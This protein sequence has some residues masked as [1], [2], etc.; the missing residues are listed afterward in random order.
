MRSLLGILIVLP[1]LGVGAESLRV[2]P[3]Q[4]VSLEAAAQ[5]WRSRARNAGEKRDWDTAEENL[6]QLMLAGSLDDELDQLHAYVLYHREKYKEA[7]IAL[8]RILK[9][10][11]R[12]FATCYYLGMSL[13]QLRHHAA[14][15]EIFWLAAAS[16]EHESER[17]W[18][19]RDELRE[20]HPAGPQLLARLKAAESLLEWGILLWE[21]REKDIARPKLGQAIRVCSQLEAQVKTGDLIPRCILVRGRAHQ[22]QQ[23]YTAAIG[24]YETLMGRYSGSPIAIQA[25]YESIVCVEKG[26]TPDACVALWEEFIRTRPDHSLAADAL[27]RLGLFLYAAKRYEESR[28]AFTRFLDTCSSPEKSAQVYHKIGIIYVLMKEYLNGAAQFEKL[29]LKYPDSALVPSAMYWTGDS[30]LKAGQSAKSYEA[31][32]R[33]I[34]RFPDSKWGKYARGR[35]TAPE[36]TFAGLFPWYRD[37]QS[38]E[39]TAFLRA[40]AFLSHED[41]QAAIGDGAGVAPPEVNLSAEQKEKSLKGARAFRD[42]CQAHPGSAVTPAA[43]YFAGR[44][45]FKLSRYRDAHHFLSRAIAA[46]PDGKWAKRSRLLLQHAAFEDV[47]KAER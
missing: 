20:V 39:K 43:A 19:P 15:T 45:Y 8:Y 46:S 14:A 33:T 6:R 2:R 41:V 17:L 35:L 32:S 44:L 37:A 31:F 40:M 7:V 23:E 26:E 27:M 18:Y 3:E 12:C 13:S 28:K 36:L 47:R 1:S 22:A 16:T 21:H 38:E 24:V 5:I 42:F 10:N 4:L 34:Q 29:P 30:Y 11:P 9:S 25:K